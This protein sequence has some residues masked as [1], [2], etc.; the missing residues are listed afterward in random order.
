MDNM[1]KEKPEV[2]A[3]G[4]FVLITGFILIFYQATYI[5]NRPARLQLQML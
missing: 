3:S 2:A 1:A 4:F 5:C